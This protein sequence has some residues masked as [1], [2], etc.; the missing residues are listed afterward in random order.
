MRLR[1]VVEEGG[2]DPRHDGPLRV[3]QRT[4]VPARGTGVLCPE[5]H[6]LL[7]RRRLEGPGEQ[8]LDGRHGD[9][10]HLREVDVQSR[11]VL[12]PVLPDDDFSPAPRQFL[13]AAQIL[14]GRLPG[15][16]VASLQEFG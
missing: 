6:R 1:F 10:F 14:G 16:H 2:A 4:N 8:G 11:S 7:L 3:L 12:A 13:D 9:I 5:L 15:C